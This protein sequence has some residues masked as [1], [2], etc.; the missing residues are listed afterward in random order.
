MLCYEKNGK[1]SGLNFPPD[2]S[3][4]PSAAL[5]SLSTLPTVGAAT[6]TGG[7]AVANN[8][9]LLGMPNL[10]NLSAFTGHPYQATTQQQATSF[11]HHLAMPNHAA[12]QQATAPTPTAA[13]QAA[14]QAQHASMAPSIATSVASAVHN[15]H[16][17]QQ[18][19]AMM[20]TPAH[21]LTTTAM[22]AQLVG[23]P[24]AL[25]K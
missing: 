5:G 13:G 6:F 24:S 9:P 7:S 3:N 25:C 16:F 20:S 4:T 21:Q 12:M 22:N 11:A 2:H 18:L 10:V 17:A 15:P 8:S 1:K 14:S 19:A 23:T